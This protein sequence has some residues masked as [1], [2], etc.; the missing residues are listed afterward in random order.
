MSATARVE[1]DQLQQPQTV[2][3]PVCGM[4][5]TPEDAVESIEHEAT[6]YYFCSRDCAESFSEAPEDFT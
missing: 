2:K 4:M 3:D 6:T 1:R 5:I